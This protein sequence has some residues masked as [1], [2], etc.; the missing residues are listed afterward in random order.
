MAT[1]YPVSGCRIF[2]GATMAVPDVDSVAADF[3]AVSWTEIKGWTSMGSSGDASALITTA[4]ISRGRDVKQK[5][6]RNAGQMQN[7]FAVIASDAGQLALLAAEGTNDNFPFKVEMNDEEAGSGHTPSTRLF[8]GLVTSAQEA[9]GNA[10]TVRN[11]QSA[12]EIN[13]NIVRVAAT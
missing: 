7:E 10:N 5:G 8:I 4:L 6:T 11:L 9:G 2:I 1:L 12:I 13:T 3:S